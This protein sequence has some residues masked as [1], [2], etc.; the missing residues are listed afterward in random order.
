[1][2]ETEWTEAQRASAVAELA[3]GTHEGLAVVMAPPPSFPD[4]PGFFVDIQASLTR[5][6]LRKILS[7]PMHLALQRQDSAAIKQ[8]VDEMFTDLEITLAERDLIYQKAR[9]RRIAG[10]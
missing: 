7:T 9:A 4:W 1:M 2:I 10:F 6:S 8:D 5:K 3:T